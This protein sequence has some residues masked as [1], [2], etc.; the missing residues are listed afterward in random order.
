MAALQTESMQWESIT[1]HKPGKPNF[2][3]MYQFNIPAVST[4]GENYIV[5]LVY[6]RLPDSEYKLLVSSADELDMQR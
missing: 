4:R 5:R 3:T 6:E 2:Q 1:V